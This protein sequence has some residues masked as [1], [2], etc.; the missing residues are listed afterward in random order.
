M[1]DEQSE[2]SLANQPKLGTW[3]AISI[4][5]GI[6]IGSSIFKTAPFIFSN[7]TG[8]WM[9]LG[10]WA[11][12]GFLALVGAFCYAEL[13]TT[14]P[15][16]GGDY[17]YLT[18]AFHP[19]VGFLFGWAQLAVI[20]TGST[21]MM[22]F[23]FGD[24]TASLFKIEGEEK[25]VFSVACAVVSVL[26]LSVLN[27][28]GVV[29]GKT[30]QNVLTYIKLTGMGAIVVGGF[31][32]SRADTWTAAA[33]QADQPFS[34]AS[35]GVAL[36][37]VLYGYGGWNDAAFIAAD[38]RDRRDITK[39]LVIGTAGITLIYLA[40]NAA[41]IMGLG[42]AGARTS[43]AIAADV[44]AN[45][46]GDFGYNAMCLLV[47]ISA[48]GAINGLI[49]TGSRVYSALG[50]EH[51][52]FAVLGRW[53]P[54]FGSPV[55]SLAAQ[56]I[57]SIAMI[58][59]VGTEAGKNAV[60]QGLARAG[61]PQIPFA[62]PKFG[63][64]GFQTLFAGTAPVFWSF[65]LLTGISVFVLR[66]KDRDL[67]RPFRLQP[68]FYPLLPVIFC[69]M[70]LF[71]LYSSVTFAEGVVVIGLVPLA[72]GIPLYFVSRRTAESAGRSET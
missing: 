16:S 3:D 10:V 23:V 69:G 2:T 49:F 20:L 51:S 38:M 59:L 8:P 27:V 55:W 45:L 5:I 36:I 19:A 71:G 39:A 72:V 7:V 63:N 58:F 66:A 44:L 29:F 28:L 30:V 37:L 14:Y 65:F 33:W 61:L 41:Y 1:L 32:A 57:I 67:D 70:C 12:G 11:L 64:D 31:F 17:V 18:R 46:L 15:R 26:V 60:N 4:I 62:H 9:G 56:A 52:V 34:L 24:Y 40:V 47:M 25:A 21:G 68:P 6:V 43:E 42:M 13:A 54:R 35:F 53:H 50:S 22:A 48:L